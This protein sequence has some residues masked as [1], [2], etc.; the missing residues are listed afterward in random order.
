MEFPVRKLLKYSES[1]EPLVWWE[2]LFGRSFP[3]IQPFLTPS[4]DRRAEFYPSPE[5]PSVQLTVRESGRKYRA[6]PPEEHEDEL[7]DII[8]DWE[9]V[10][11]HHL[12]CDR[13]RKSI[14]KTF[15][16]KPAAGR[17]RDNLLYIGRCECNRD[18]RHVYA[19]LA[20]SSHG[21][22]QA[23]EEC[24]DPKKVGCVLFPTHRTKAADLLK[25][26]GIA[27]VDLRECLSQTP[28]GFAGECPVNCASCFLPDTGQLISRLDT[29]EKTVLPDAAR[30]SKTKKSASAGGKARAD[31]YL[32]K[33][34]E[35]KRFILKCHHDNPFISFTEV[36]RKAAQHASI[37]ERALKNHLKKSDFSDW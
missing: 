3:S 24:T 34:E 25:T 13:L 37:S 30:G 31:G 14:R 4:E 28:S 11:A 21:S 23:M 12:D 5:R 27:S 9:D 20:V 18:F 16:L 8:L 19:C 15:R 22:L 26:R 17:K 2:N 7:D 6:V 33:Y 36:R 32:E 1:F 10:Q 35:A 29:I